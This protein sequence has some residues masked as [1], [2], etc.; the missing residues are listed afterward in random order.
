MISWDSLQ[1]A[2]APD[3]G[4]RDEKRALRGARD[5]GGS[6]NSS[7]FICINRSD[8]RR[9]TGNSTASSSANEVVPLMENIT[10]CMHRKN[11]EVLNGIIP[12]FKGK[13]LLTRFSHYQSRKSG[14]VS[15]GMTVLLT[16]E[17]ELIATH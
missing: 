13:L 14:A 7:A 2:N 4:A 8:S 9:E 6:W 11:D 12:Q 10:K 3:S 15:E 5:G 16:C 17:L 1:H